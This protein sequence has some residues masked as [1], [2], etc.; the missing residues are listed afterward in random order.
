MGCP[1]CLLTVLTLNQLKAAG[2][3]S[4]QLQYI[5]LPCRWRQIHVLLYVN[6]LHLAT[7]IISSLSAIQSSSHLVTCGL[8]QFPSLWFLPLSWH[9]ASMV[10]F[11]QLCVIELWPGYARC[12]C[13]G[14]CVWGAP[15]PTCSLI[16]PTG[17][18]TAS[19]RPLTFMATHTRPSL[20][21]PRCVSMPHS[22]FVDN[23]YY[24]K[25]SSKIIFVV[26][27][28]VMFKF[29]LTYV[30]CTLEMNVNQ[31]SV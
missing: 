23:K 6:I 9:S 2:T 5:H 31:P 8:W 21:V 20:S 15:M 19:W 7:V 3:R 13:G 22:V 29:C 11:S 4:C 16:V 14:K 12:C 27:W 1:G 28:S 25:T 30:F 17:K 26:I 24:D 18:L 10:D